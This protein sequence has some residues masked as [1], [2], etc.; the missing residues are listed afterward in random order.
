MLPTSRSETRMDMAWLSPETRLAEIHAKLSARKEVD[1]VTVKTFLR[2]FGAS[3]RGFWVVQNVEHMLSEAGLQTRPD[4]NAVHID[5]PVRF[6]LRP[7]RPRETDAKEV[8]PSSLSEPTSATVAVVD[9]GPTLIAGAS[10]DPATTPKE[11]IS[12]T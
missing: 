5:S 4:F 8:A 1:A 7:H 6:E 11:W 10:A 2:W 9:G 3:R 12:P